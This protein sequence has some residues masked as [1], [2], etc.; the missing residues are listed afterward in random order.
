MLARIRTELSY[1]A[2]RNASQP[3]CFEA[4]MPACD[5][6]LHDDEPMPVLILRFDGPWMDE[7]TRALR[8]LAVCTELHAHRFCSST[9]T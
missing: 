6:R 5:S 9:S 2:A 1:A 7:R 8:Q 3:S 4:R